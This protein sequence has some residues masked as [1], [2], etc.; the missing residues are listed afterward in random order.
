MCGIAGFWRKSGPRDGDCQRLVR[1]AG[2]LTHRG[3]DDFGYLY[4]NTLNGKT[5]I[6]QNDKT[7][8]APNLFL[9]NRRL[10]I[11]DLS[12]AGRQPIT[13]ENNDIF[14]VFNGAIHNFIELRNELKVRGH[15]FN[16]ETDTEVLLRA[17]EEWDADCATRFNGMWSYAIWDQRKGRLVCSRDRFGIKPFFTATV[18]DTFYFASEAKSILAVEKAAREANLGYIQHLFKTWTPLEGRNSA[19]KDVNQLPAGHNRIVTDKAITE[20]RYWEYNNP[21]TKYDYTN[22]EETFGD[23]FNDAVKIRL[24]GDVPVSVLLSGGIDST[25]VAVTA[26]RLAPGELTAFT[27]RFSGFHSDES[28]YA[29]LAAEHAHI[30]LTLVDYCPK[31]FLDDL[32][33]VTWH[34]DAPAAKGQMLARWHLIREASRLGTILLEGQGADEFLGGYPNRHTL[35]YILSELKQL[36]LSTMPGGL[37]RLADTTMTRDNRQ[38]L[39]KEIRNKLGFKKEPLGELFS[40]G[41]RALPRYG[42]SDANTN[43]RMFEDPLTNVLLKDHSRLVLPYLLH[44]GDAISMGHSME[45]RLPFLDHRL[46]EFVFGLPLQQK[47]RGSRAKVILRESL[48]KELPKSILARRK[49]VG[50]STPYD[51]WIT[52]NFHNQIKPLLSSSRFRDRGVFCPDGMRQLLF[53]F[54]ANSERAWQVFRCASVELWFRQFIDGDGF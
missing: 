9:A 39:L 48:K 1:M 24:R 31:N 19:F 29:R 32:G 43:T 35:P 26:S 8:F 37:I 42:S 4:V 36:R 30:P 10:S 54:E 51:S 5:Q 40:P 45:S 13:N 38:V 23:L 53:Q 17:Y 41:I 46:V 22:P 47:I 49:K 25:A 28:Q 15:T 18:G 34:M 21:S 11:T 16:S 27:A 7:D 44:F 3:P 2:L 14:V 52:A 6:T 50:F 12:A 33:K 20:T